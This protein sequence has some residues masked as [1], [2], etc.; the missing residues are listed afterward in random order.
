MTNMPNLNPT[1]TELKLKNNNRRIRKTQ[2]K[3]SL[4][5]LCF[6]LVM[7]SGIVSTCIISP[8][9]IYDKWVQE[10]KQNLQI[11]TPPMAKS[12]QLT[13]QNPRIKLHS[14]LIGLVT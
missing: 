14:W 8:W 2:H 4:K 6:D 3:R 7:L 5:L 10:I 1:C 13:L 11:Q 12:Q 9:S